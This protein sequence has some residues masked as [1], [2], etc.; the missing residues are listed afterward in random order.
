MTAS[1]QQATPARTG[2][3]N[4][5]A[6][7]FTTPLYVGAAL[8]PINSSLIAT[9]LV[10]I[11]TALHVSV[12]STTVLVS[13]LYLASAIAQPTAGK[14][15][16]EFG[17]R[18]V[19]LT[20]ILLVLLGGLLGGFGQNMD[21]L[22]AARVLVGVGTSAGYPSAMI[23]IRRRANSAGMSAPPG[24]VLGGIAIAG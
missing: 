18:R 7:K 21:M 10:P 19:F 12:G 1:A 4:P 9:A 17:P 15:A 2:G 8:N 23:L 6:W 16:E 3:T 20:G 22:I 11:A 13:S 14:L 5:F 24:G